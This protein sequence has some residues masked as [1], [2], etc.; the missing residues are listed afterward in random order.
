VIVH[1]RYN[2]R[3]VIVGYD[4]ICCAPDEW[5]QMMR[6]DSLPLGRNQPFYEVL[7]DERDRPGAQSCYVA[8]ENVMP[9]RAPREVRHPLVP[10]FF[11]AFSPEEGGY[12]PSPLLRAA[13]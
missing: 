5:C 3:G 2:Y 7:V 8:Q 12:V 4:P 10:H 1:A 13:Y 6:V 11:S 9:M